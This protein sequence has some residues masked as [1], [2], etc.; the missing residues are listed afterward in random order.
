MKSKIAAACVAITDC[1]TSLPSAFNTATEMVDW[2]TSS[3]TYFTL[4]MGV[5]FLCRSY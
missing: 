5:P 1:I 3:P 4:F 2:W